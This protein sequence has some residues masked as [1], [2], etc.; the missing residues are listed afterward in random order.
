MSSKYEHIKEYITTIFGVF[1]NI[2][3]RSREKNDKRLQMISL[4]IFN[5]LNYLAKQNNVDL[6]TLDAKH[7]I[8]MKVFFDYVNTHNIEFYDFSKINENDVDVT[9]RE[10]LERFV[11]THIYY[12][13][14]QK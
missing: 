4:L 14:Q 3:M 8:H 6:K 12:I 1:N 9:K 13:T 5:Y 10:D 11:L 7:E 2:H